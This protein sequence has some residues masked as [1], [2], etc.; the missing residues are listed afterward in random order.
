[1]T[2]IHFSSDDEWHAIRAKHV[3]ASEVAALFGLSPFQT[4]WQLHMI[5]AGKLARTDLSGNKAVSAG[6]FMEAGVGA[7][8]AEKFGVTLN[9]VRRYLSDDEC[10][11]LGA[12]LDFECV[13]TGT[14]YPVEIKFIQRHDGWEWEGDDLTQV[15]ENYLLQVQVQLACSGAPFGDLVAFIGGDIRRLRVPRSE[16]LIAAIRAEVTEFWADVRNGKE[17]APDFVKD[18]DGIADL[19][20]GMPLRTITLPVE[21]EKL[22]ETALEQAE[23][24]KA[25]ENASKAAKAELTKMVIDA[26]IGNDDKARSECGPYKMTLTKVQPNPGKIITAEMVGE[27]TGKRAGYLL[28]KISTKKETE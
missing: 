17:P 3:G 9:K 1:M 5:K 23:I 19:A 12:S 27:V 7:W 22:F 14:R 16:K 18:A 4:R 28:A 13:G 26:G 20:Y 24:A 25:A 15:P 8:A 11:G 21:A 6:R 10:H 2:S